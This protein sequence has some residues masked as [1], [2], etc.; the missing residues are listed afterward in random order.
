MEYTK[1]LL[2]CDNE[3]YADEVSSLL[4]KEGIACRLHDE[5]NDT[6]YSYGAHGGN[7]PGIEVRVNESDYERAL[8]RRLKVPAYKP[9]RPGCSCYIACDIGAYNTC[10]HLCRYCYANYSAAAVRDSVRRHDPASPFLI[11]NYRADDVIH[12]VPQ[13][14]WIDGQTAL[15]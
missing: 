7:L 10:P 15:L 11:G 13:K 3:F 1:V 12:D 4:E 9:A 6:A 14:S 2:H 5:R 8:G